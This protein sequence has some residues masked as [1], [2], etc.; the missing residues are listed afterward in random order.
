VRILK[1]GAPAPDDG[2]WLSPW[3]WNQVLRG[4]AAQAE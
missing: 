3:T 1:A 2:Y 4:L